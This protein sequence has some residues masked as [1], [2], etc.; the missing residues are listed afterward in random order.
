M[1]T[2]G[3]ETYASRAKRASDTDEAINYLVK[4]IEE[5][6]SAIKQLESSVRRLKR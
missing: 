1:S 5:L 3:A 2:S 4:A 6:S